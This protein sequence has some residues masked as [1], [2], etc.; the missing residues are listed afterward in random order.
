MGQ[1]SIETLDTLCFYILEKYESI[2]HYKFSNE[3]LILI[4]F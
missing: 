3:I 2:L 1:L 4:K